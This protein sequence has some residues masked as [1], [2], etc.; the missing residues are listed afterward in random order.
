M[1]IAKLQVQCECQDQTVGSTSD[2][3]YCGSNVENLYGSGSDYF[4][5]FK[6]IL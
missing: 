3:F 2:T 4:G 5:R 1:D 6:C